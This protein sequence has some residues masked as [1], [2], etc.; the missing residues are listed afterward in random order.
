MEFPA[1]RNP[2][3]TGGTTDRTP[4]TGDGLAGSGFWIPEEVAGCGLGIPDGVAGRRRAR[5]GRSEGLVLL[6]REFTLS[7]VEGRVAGRPSPHARFSMLAPTSWLSTFQLSTLDRAPSGFSMLAPTSWLST[8]QLS[9][10]DWAPSGFSMPAP[11]S[12]LSTFQLSTLDCEL[13]PVW[14]L[15]FSLS[16][17]ESALTKNRACKSF[18][19]HSYKF[20][21]LKVPWNDTLTKNTGVGGVPQE[22][23]KGGKFAA[24][25]ARRSVWTE[26]M[27]LWPLR[28]CASFVIIAIRL[29]GHA[30][31]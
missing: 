9:T 15:F 21:G 10:F 4:E 18:R 13:L 23:N 11:T 8:F 17:L 16:P 24:N 3:R 26:A 5:R 28:G 7:A 30:A 12:W 29:S 6:I 27:S 19:I 31:E 14:R 1:G 22:C 25:S 2:G 20:I